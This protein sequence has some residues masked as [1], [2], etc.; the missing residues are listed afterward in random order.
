MEALPSTSNPFS[1]ISQDTTL[2]FSVR[3]DEAPKFLDILQDIPEHTD[4]DCEGRAW[5]MKANKNNGNISQNALRN[6]ATNA[7]TE[8]VDL[9]KV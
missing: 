6:W 8:F 3:W 4:S 5:V 9:L 1:P 2:A 7:W